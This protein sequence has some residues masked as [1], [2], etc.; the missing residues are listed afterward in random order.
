MTITTAAA[1]S[2][3]LTEVQ[4]TEYHMQTLI[5][6]RQRSVN[7]KLLEKFPTSSDMPFSSLKLIGSAAKKTV[8]RPIDDVDVLAVFSNSG[9]AYEKYRYDSQK[10]LYRIRQA[11][12]GLSI[13]QVGARGQA[14]R[15][16]FEQGGHV[17]IAPVFS[18]GGDDY[19]LPAGDGSWIT[20]SPLKGT[21]WF[22]A[23]NAELGYNLAPLVQLLKSWNREHSSQF[24]SFHLETV[25]GHSFGTLG[26]NY[27][28]GLKGFFEWSQSRLSVP[29][30][31]GHSSDIS[32]YLSWEKRE[33]LKSTLK[34]YAARATR[35]IAAENNGN[36]SEA[37]RL[38]RIILGDKFP[39]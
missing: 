34:T 22:Q 12:S 8:I 5:P 15:V 20:T 26:S 11:Y 18:T 38:W 19:L 9:R 4:P 30:P 2:L 24:K 1:M 3:F 27:R 39:A 28:T 10:F 35:A 13:H 21:T 36:H 29:D 32:D 14:V 37:K 17:D 6:A 7:E 25:A 33:N 16:F 23:K 31:G